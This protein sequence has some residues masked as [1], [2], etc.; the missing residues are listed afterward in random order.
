MLLG[1]FARKIGQ[2]LFHIGV[3][4]FAL[5]QAKHQ[6]TKARQEMVQCSGEMPINEIKNKI[7]DW[8][9]DVIDVA[10]GKACRFN[11]SCLC[12][13]AR[14][15]CSHEFLFIYTFIYLFVCLFIN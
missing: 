9:N 5:I 4:A 2:S 7:F 12:L 1:P 10:N 8:V 3:C 6:W 14:Y 13:H 15:L 11:L